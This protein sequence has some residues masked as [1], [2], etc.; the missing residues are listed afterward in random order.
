[1]ASCECG[2]LKR[3]WAVVVECEGVPANIISHMFCRTLF[4][5]HHSSLFHAQLMTDDNFY[6]L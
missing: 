3:L 4:K 5:L 1:M 6:Y 2:L